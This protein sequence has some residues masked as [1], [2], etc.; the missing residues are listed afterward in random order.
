[1]AATIGIRRFLGI[2]EREIALP[3]SSGNHA[4]A[5]RHLTIDANKEVLKDIPAFQH[6]GERLRFNFIPKQ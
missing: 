2:G 6:A 3:F 1:L 4:A 5:T